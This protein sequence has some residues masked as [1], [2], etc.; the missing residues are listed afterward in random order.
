MSIASRE[1]SSPSSARRWIVR[2]SLTPQIPFEPAL[3]VEQRLDLLRRAPRGPGQEE[4]DGRVEVAGARAHDEAL[5]GGHPHR[6]VHAAAGLD[7]G[8]ARAVSQVERDQV[9][10]SE[11]TFQVLGR[12]LRD[13]AV[14]SPVEAVA[15]HVMLLVQ[16]EGERVVIR[17][18]RHRLVEGG[19]EHGDLGNVRH[20]RPGDLDA[21][22]VR[23]VVEGSERDLLANR[24]DHLVVDQGRLREDL[25]AVNDAMPDAEERPASSSEPLSASAASICWKPARWSGVET[26]RTISSASSPL[27]WWSLLPASPICSTMPEASTSP[28]LMSNS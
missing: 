23:R 7:R 6:G 12:P 27:R 22:D 3:G 20:A 21:D 8:C 18:G 17:A 24:G 15:A 1:R 14:G 28:P 16:I 13:A 11:R 25:A 5:E 4:G 2:M 26:S 9:Q 19:V 10:R